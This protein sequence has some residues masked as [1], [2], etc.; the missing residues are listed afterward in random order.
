[1]PN[2]RI[3]RNEDPKF[4]KFIT[5]LYSYVYPFASGVMTLILLF[6]GALVSSLCFFLVFLLVLPT[7]KEKL[8]KIKI[9]GLIKLIICLVLIWLG[10]YS[11]IFK[12]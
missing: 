9:K 2:K 8:E 5:N 1:M 12:I 6:N 11:T 3:F 7:M 10:L 4:V